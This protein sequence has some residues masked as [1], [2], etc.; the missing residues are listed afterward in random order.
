MDIE[1]IIELMDTAGVSKTI[2]STRG[3]VSPDR[4]L[5]F[6]EKHRGRIIPAVRTK[7]AIYDDDSPKYYKKLNKQLTM[8]GFGAMAEVIMW[9]ARKGDKAPE[10]IVP[11]DDRRVAA[12]LD[13]ALKHGWPFI[14]HI[15]FAASGRDRTVFMEK[16]EALLKKHPDHPFVLI[17]MGQLEIKDVSRLVAVYPNI[18]FIAAHSNP[19]STGESKQPWVNMFTGNIFTG[20][21]LDPAWRELIISNPDRF[22]LGFDNVFPEHWGSFY[23]QQVT[24][25]KKALEDLPHEV[26]RKLAHKNAERLWGLAPL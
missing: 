20:Y 12:A 23:L 5:A 15:E 14:A 25:W 2:H 22:I 3:K 19:I 9:H 26:A 13:G 16:F 24:L 10:V 8:D 1:R 4:L 21:R 7:G 6:A 17:H 18:Y 11:P